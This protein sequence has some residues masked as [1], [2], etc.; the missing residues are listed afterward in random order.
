MPFAPETQ[1]ILDRVQEITRVPIALGADLQSPHLLAQ[2]K[3]ARA[4][5]NGSDGE[6]NHRGKNSDATRR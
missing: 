2:V 6:N 1:A 3:M 4:K 5:S